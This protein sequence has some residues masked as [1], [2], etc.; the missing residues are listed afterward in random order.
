[1]VAAGSSY[2]FAHLMNDAWDTF[3]H[4]GLLRD[5]T[6]QSCQVI[7]P[8]DAFLRADIIPALAKGRGARPRQAT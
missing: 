1:M 8:V 4:D 2:D 3:S 7:T 5:E 6:A